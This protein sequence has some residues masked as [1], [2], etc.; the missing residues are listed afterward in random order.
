MDGKT[1]LKLALFFVLVGL[2]QFMFIRSL[3][4]SNDL[5]TPKIRSGAMENRPRMTRI[6]AI[7]FIPRIST[8]FFRI[9]F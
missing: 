6:R 1:L 4:N 9:Y 7:K 5:S 8:D 2:S 3:W